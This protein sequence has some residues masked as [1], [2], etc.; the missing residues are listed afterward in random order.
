MERRLRMGKQHP[1]GSAQKIWGPVWVCGKTAGETGREASGRCRPRMCLWLG[2]V[3]SGPELVGDDA[4]LPLP[5]TE[6]LW[7][8]SQ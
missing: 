2:G 3:A 6:R 7:T 8:D 1:C 5:G 4:E